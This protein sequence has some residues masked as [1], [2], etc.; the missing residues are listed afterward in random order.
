MGSG[1]E[2]LQSLFPDRGLPSLSPAAPRSFI[3]ESSLLP[4]PPPPPPPL[5]L[6]S[7]GEPP[8]P[9]PLPLPPPHPLTS[10]WRWIATVNNNRNQ[11]RGERVCTLS[12][13]FLEKRFSQSS[14]PNGLMARWMR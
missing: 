7:G 10:R 5:L 8:P 2:L 11:K 4:P 9:L 12:A 3:K 13:S 1:W 6:P 14:Q